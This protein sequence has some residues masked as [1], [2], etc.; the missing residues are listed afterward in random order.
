MSLKQVIVVR[1]DLKMG[2]GKIASQCCHASLE[3]FLKTQK[4]ES[5]LASQWLKE[6]MPKIIL[7]ANSL[8][9]LT[10]IIKQVENASLNFAV[11]KDAGKTQVSKGSITALGIGPAGEKEIDKI[12]GKLKLL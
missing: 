4:K 1:S 9:A 10:E 5:F 8:K 3:S 11:I 2:K 6:G 12:T 7:K